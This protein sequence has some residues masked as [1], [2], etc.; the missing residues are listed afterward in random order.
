MGRVAPVGMLVSTLPSERLQAVEHAPKGPGSRGPDILQDVRDFD[1]AV[2]VARPETI[3]ANRV[4]H[5]FDRK[6]T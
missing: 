3:S 6:G 1:I 2:A 5:S 4:F